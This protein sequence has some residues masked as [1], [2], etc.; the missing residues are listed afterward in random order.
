MTRLKNWLSLLK[1]Y[2]FCAIGWHFY[3]PLWRKKCIR[4]KRAKK[5]G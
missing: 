4:C 2:P 1:R 5:N 3:G